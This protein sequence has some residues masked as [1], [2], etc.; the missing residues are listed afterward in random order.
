MKYIALLLVIVSIEMYSQTTPGEYTVKNVITNTKDSDFG[1]SFFGKDKVV[2]AA[3]KDNTV[4]TK[5]TWSGNNQAF[6]DLYIGTINEKGEIIGKKR[7]LGDVNGKFHEGVVSFTKD[8][9]TVY[10]SANNYTDKNKAKK[11]STGM[12]NIQ[13]YKASVGDNGE[14][15]NIIKLPFNNDEYSTGHPSLN[16][17]D[18]KLYFISDR[19][20][21]VGKTDIYVVDVNA[22]DTYSEPKN[23][24][25][26]INTEEREMFPFI[27]D[28]NVLYFSSTGHPGYGALDVFASRIFDTTVSEPI[29]LEDPVN[30]SN[31]D[32][33]FIINDDKHKGYFSS[34]NRKDGKGD[35]DIYSFIAFP[36]LQIEGNQT[37][38]G[39]VIDKETQK[40]I[41]EAIV[42]LQDENGNELERVKVSANTESNL[43]PSIDDL[44]LNNQENTSVST[45]EVADIHVNKIVDNPTPKVGEDVEF[46]VE[47]TNKGT[48]EATEI[49]VSDILPEGF[50]YV[51]DDGS[52]TYRPETDILILPKLAAGE[53]TTIKIKA[54]IPNNDLNQNNEDNTT[55]ATG[56]VA[57][58]HVN[59]TVDNPTPNAGEEVEFTVEVTNN[60]K[61]EAT[62]I[63]VSDILPEGF[64]YVHDDGS[65]TYEPGTDILTLPKLAAGEKTTIKIKAIIPNNDLNQNNEDNTT[66][67]TGEVV[68][69]HVNKTVDNP[70]PN[71][72][73]E[74]EF[75]VEVTNKG[76][77]EATEVKVSDILPEGYEYIHDDGSGTYE[78][79]T[80]IL[81]LPKL[82]A[83]EKTTIK[84]KAVTTTTNLNQKN[85][86]KVSA[87][88]GDVSD[89]R[90]NKRVDKLNPKTGDEVEFTVEIT[91]NG[92]RKAKGIKVS[93]I[94]PEGYT[95]VS[96]DGT[97]TY[98]S[99]TDDITLPNL[100][101]GE[102]QTVKIKA[103][104]L[105]AGRDGSFNFVAKSDTKYKVVV[106]A[107]G[108]LKEE[109]DIQTVNDTDV[110]PLEMNVSLA[111][112]L[113]VVDEKIMININTIYFDFDKWNIR[114]EAAKELDKVIGVM[115][116]HPS[117]VIEG[118]SHT[119]SRAREAYNQKL[120][121]KRAKSTVDYIVARGI[122]RSRITAK[123]YGELQLINN[124]SSFVKCTREEHQLNRRT[125]F[126]I[127][128]DN[129]KFASNAATL[130]NVKI[131]KK[132]NLTFVEVGSNLNEANKSEAKK[133]TSNESNTEESISTQSELINI[134][135][136]YFDFDKWGISDTELK[137]LDNVVQIMKDN[138]TIVVEASSHTDSKNLESY[139]QLLS[140]KR[141]R[142]VVKYI[143]SKGINPDRIIGKGYGEMKLTNHCK[144]F[145]KCTPEE[146][147]ANRRTEFKIIKM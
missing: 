86:D 145:V 48:G 67:A 142:S 53:K 109:T 100:A 87:I 2:F 30:S 18:T 64:E 78:P 111:Q 98:V 28:D 119:D 113:R 66:V 72:G 35:D 114:P 14:W 76:T 60:G 65:G 84:I 77:G 96:D 36:P 82:A 56:E 99:T 75:T 69:V 13:L 38:S 22:D 139:N 62:E 102:T 122:D 140:E 108:Y 10:F 40:L 17:D 32:F 27:S 41:P 52:G 70:T 106:I 131:D 146:Q 138:P 34:N 19:Y 118:G 43:M 1:T 58:V 101:K 29:N 20:G 133:A 15:T 95:Y 130:E 129:D 5:K 134:P 81:T 80:D 137:Q 104:L 21:S 50:E 26:K 144:S 107:P 116:E 57:D 59:K 127:V 105:P 132:A 94:L 85:R 126:V 147:Q 79:G 124:C 44:N 31:D 47:V 61:G 92:T 33:A 91:N 123:G 112:E 97:G 45:G 42:V 121:E 49:K 128:N 115:K 9:K 120:S 37:I 136:I 51:H 93:D 46:T 23:L 71:A 90:I 7:V 25:P 68:D 143:T 6:L 110:D 4:L 73:E 8:L 54:V 141:A 83:G 24:G 88:T 11:D 3:P 55:V 74:V 39:I 16:I 63:K 135:P 12:V 117:M 103:I 89:I 125:E